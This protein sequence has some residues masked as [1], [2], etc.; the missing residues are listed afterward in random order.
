[1]IR[2]EERGQHREHLVGGLLGRRNGPTPGMTTLCTSSVTGT[3]SPA[4][5][6]KPDAE[7]SRG[8]GDLRRSSL[9]FTPAARAARATTT[10]TR[11]HATVTGQ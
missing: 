6:P 10:A 1:V 11:I 8:H 4:C 5:S 3:A 9:V 7:A 2:R